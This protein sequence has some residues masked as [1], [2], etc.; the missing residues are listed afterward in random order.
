MEKYVITRPWIT[1]Q[2]EGDVVE[3]QKLH[4]SLVSHVRLVTDNR[5]FEVATPSPEID[6]L[7]AALIAAEAALK[8]K[9]DEL[10]SETDRANTAEAALKAATTKGK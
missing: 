10:S 5:E 1:G 6:E 2:K 7:K 8:A 4:P 3:L 9:D